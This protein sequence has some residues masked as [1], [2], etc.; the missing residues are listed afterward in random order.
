MQNLLDIIVAI[1]TRPEIYLGRPS[2]DRLYAFIGGYL[3]ANPEA[4]DHCL[5]GFD[6]FV[7]AKYH[8][9][10][11]HN[12]SEIIQFFS[13]NGEQQGFDTFIKLFNEFAGLT[14]KHQPK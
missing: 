2:L 13:P 10:T 7:S 14:T 12:W 9:N 1:S 8:I 4:D 6:E 11:D 5:A 3:L